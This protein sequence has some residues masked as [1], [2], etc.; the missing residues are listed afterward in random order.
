MKTIEETQ[1]LLTQYR[2]AVKSCDD[3]LYVI[4]GDNM[5]LNRTGYS[6]YELTKEDWPATFK[7]DAAK[8]KLRIYRPK[9]ELIHLEMV[10]YN[11]WLK[12]EIKKHEKLLK[13]V[14]EPVVETYMEDFLHIDH[15]ELVEV[16][17]EEEE[18]VE[19]NVQGPICFDLNKLTNPKCPVD[20]DN[21]LVCKYL[22]DVTLSG[23]VLS[24]IC[25]K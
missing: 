16:E 25:K 17:E 11:D 20:C 23:D 7:K 2:E 22:Q 14:D 24:V 12:T 8:E 4:K 18:M 3:K 15:P 21:C 10:S 1:T 13:G 6:K 9:Y 5:T 19:L